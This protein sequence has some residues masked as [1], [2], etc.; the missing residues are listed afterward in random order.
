V[1]FLKKLFGGSEKFSLPDL[2][3]IGTD[4]H[5]HLIPGIDDGVKTIEESIMLIKGLYELG[6]RKLIITP[7]IM[8]DYYQNTP[9]II[10]T[11][12]LRVKEAL[13][14]EKIDMK[15]DAAAEYYL[16]FNFLEKI[17]KKELLTLGDNYVL[18]ELS[19]FNPPQNLNEVIFSLQTSG[20]KAILAHPE[21]YVYWYN[22]FN[23]YVELKNRGVYFQLNINSLTGE[24]SVPTRK[25][26]E[27]LIK[28]DFVNFLG[29]DMHHE[30]HLNLLHEVLENKH[31]FQLVTSG[32]IMNHTL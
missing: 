22:D 25:I 4:V 14:I 27:K 31:L 23:K 30:R 29:T 3:G 21:R 18:F 10:R 7:H 9:E 5:S 8:S 17:E 2:S 16:D 24:Y 32:R 20:Y 13:S 15:V 19:Y 1:G 28:E 11:G 12:L 6:Y 26:A